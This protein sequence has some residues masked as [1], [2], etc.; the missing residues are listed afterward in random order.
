MYIY[1]N[2]KCKWDGTRLRWR[3][4]LFTYRKKNNNIVL[5]FAQTGRKLDFKSIVSNNTRNRGI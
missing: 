1:G 2:K 4:N 5:T 3:F